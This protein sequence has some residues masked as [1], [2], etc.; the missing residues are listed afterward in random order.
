[1][2]ASAVW[3]RISSI[4][5]FSQEKADSSGSTDEDSGKVVCAKTTVSTDLVKSEQREKEKWEKKVVWCECT[6]CSMIA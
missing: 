2:L 5:S 6:Y 4:M 3:R 1:M